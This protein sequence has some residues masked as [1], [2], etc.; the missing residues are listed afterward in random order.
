MDL[1]SRTVCSCFSLA[2]LVGLAAI[3]F[4]AL[5]AGGILKEGI[6]PI[7]LWWM[8]LSGSMLLHWCSPPGRRVVPELRGSRL[9][10]C[11]GYTLALWMVCN[12]ESCTGELIV[13]AYLAAERG[14]MWF[15]ARRWAEFTLIKFVTWQKWALLVISGGLGGAMTGVIANWTIS[16]FQ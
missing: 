14:A 5:G 13:A 12:R 10:V 6:C 15:V 9:A 11:C 7:L 8:L 1:L 4:V 16:K 2:L 3:F